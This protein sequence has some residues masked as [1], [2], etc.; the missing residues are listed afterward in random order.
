MFNPPLN[1]VEE[2]KWLLAVTNLKAT[3]SVFDKPNEN[4][5]F[6]ITI[7]GHWVS[8]SADQTMD[9]LNNLLVLRTQ[10][11][12]EL[13]VEQVRK[14]GLFLISDYSLSSLGTSK[15]K[16]LEEFRNAKY[17]DLED[18]VYRFQLT[19][20]EIIGV[21]DLKFTPTKRR[22]YSLNPGIYEVIVLNETLK[23]ILPDNVKV[24]ITID[25][26]RLKSILET[27]Q[28]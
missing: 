1:L 3:S 13:H 16:I 17:N 10:N 23:Y 5:S 19:Y 7:P 27:N 20:D 14:K 11:D 8:K 18:L 9:E 25:A 15:E 2:G 4:T 6:S 26:I 24:S 22:S 21:L 28:T 12:I